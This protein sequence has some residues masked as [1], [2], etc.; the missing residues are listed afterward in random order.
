MVTFYEQIAS[1]LKPEDYDYP[2]I[3]LRQAEDNTEAAKE[4]LEDWL[5][6]KAYIIDL[7]V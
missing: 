7:F 5:Q 2:D 3:T 6:I 4:K 1:L